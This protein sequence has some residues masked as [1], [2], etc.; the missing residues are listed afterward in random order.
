MLGIRNCL[1]FCEHWWWIGY[2]ISTWPTCHRSWY[3]LPRPFPHH[4]LRCERLTD[5]IF[6]CQ[7]YIDRLADKLSACVAAKMKLFDSPT[8]PTMPV[9]R[10]FMENGRYITGPCGWLVT[11]C[12]VIKVHTEGDSSEHWMWTLTPHYSPL[13]WLCY[14]RMHLV[15]NFTE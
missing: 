7:L 6:C 13:M 9:P 1:W 4:P 8:G 15:P 11:R 12:H 10:L 5:L 2:S 3:D 14:D